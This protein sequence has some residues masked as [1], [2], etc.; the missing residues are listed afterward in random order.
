MSR[1]QD[2]VLADTPLVLS[3]FAQDD[4]GELVA[5]DYAVGVA[6]QLVTPN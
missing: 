2:V 4:G 5:L 6:Y 3:S 1:W